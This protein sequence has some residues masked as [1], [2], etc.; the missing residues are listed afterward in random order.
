MMN[1]Y[2][3][4]LPE[5]LAV[6]RAR[7]G[8]RALCALAAALIVAVAIFGWKYWQQRQTAR[9]AVLYEQ[10]QQTI[11][12]EPASSVDKKETRIARI[13]TE[14]ENRFGRTPYAQMGAL[15]A[16]K[17]LYQAANAQAAKVQLQ[18]A[19]DVA[20]DVEYRQ[21]ARLRLSA[22]LLEEKAYDEALR[23]LNSGAS[24]P[25]FA[26]LRAQQRGDALAAQG[27]R[28]QAR[29]AYRDALQ[30]LDAKNTAARQWVQLKLNA[31]GG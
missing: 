29:A 15:A 14:L 8:K 9:A 25:A 28:E 16:A 27:Q 18:W 4:Y 17:A 13:A 2:T 23:V 19:A 10:L 6:W 31:L 1:P 22:L 12:S 24:T 11:S 21:I 5:R 7:W 26:A 30:S 20:I 3:Q